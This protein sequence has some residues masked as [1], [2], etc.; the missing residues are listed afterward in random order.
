MYT[1]DESVI[2][3]LQDSFKVNKGSESEQG[4]K[5]EVHSSDVGTSFNSLNEFN[6]VKPKD[7]ER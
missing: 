7:S 1:L 4:R 2:S 5:S 6:Q 3:T